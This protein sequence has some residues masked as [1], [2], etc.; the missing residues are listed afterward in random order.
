MEFS[1]NTIPGDLSSGLSGN[2]ATTQITGQPDSSNKQALLQELKSLVENTTGNIS[3][4]DKTA[5]LKM[6][7]DLGRNVVT[8]KI[9]FSKGAQSASVFSS[10]KGVDAFGDIYV[11]SK[12]LFIAITVFCEAGT[13]YNQ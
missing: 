7:T 11:E 13:R 3:Y 6:N 8:Q 4:K 10:L 12:G 5:T 9:D 2:I 1:L